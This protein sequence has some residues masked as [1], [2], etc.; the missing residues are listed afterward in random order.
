MSDETFAVDWRGLFTSIGVTWRDRGSNCHR[1]NVNIPCPWCGNDPSFHLGV[2]ENIEAYYCYRDTR[3]AG[4][5][6]PHLL[7]QLG[8]SRSEGVALLN[9][10][11]GRKNIPVQAEARPLTLTTKLW[12]MFL[13]A[14][15][16]NLILW[17]LQDRGFTNP[18]LTVQRYDLRFAM[19]GKWSRRVL[20]P[21]KEGEQVLTWVG[22]TWEEGRSPRYLM[23]V[24]KVAGVV[25]VPRKPREVIVLCEGPMDAL[26]IAA[27]TEDQD[28]SAI[29]LAGKGLNASKI[30]NLARITAGKLVLFC[31][32]AD[33]P[34][35]EVYSIKSQLDAHLD[36]VHKAVL[37]LPQ[38]YK[39]PGEME[40]D[41]IVN[42][43]KGGLR[44]NS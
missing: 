28:I 13:P 10:F 14:D 27:A 17:Y 1:G 24:E 5:S 18:S 8:H 16:M 32:D 38:D 23:D 29:A 42:W 44:G 37:R 9:R 11:Q 20:I 3:H 30:L 31:P 34:V 22:R 39:D 21:F 7:H 19:S 33:V 25:Y 4:R 26:K 12:D 15:T 43:V 35:G 2:S 36:H 40:M 6:F 41:A